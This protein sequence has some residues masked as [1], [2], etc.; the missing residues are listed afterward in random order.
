MAMTLEQRVARDGHASGGRVYLTLIAR[1]AI[2]KS[3]VPCLEVYN[4][5]YGY[6]ATERLLS[7]REV[8]K[9][10]GEGYVK[11]MCIRAQQVG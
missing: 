1:A 7:K 4:H 3:G 9:Y 11:N 8:I 10:M 6:W 5:T 2:G